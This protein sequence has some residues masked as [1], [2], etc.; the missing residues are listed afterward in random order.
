MHNASQK[1][2]PI[3]M[4]NN[5]NIQVSFHLFSEKLIFSPTT[6]KYSFFSFT[7]SENLVN[8]GKTSEHP[9]P[10][11]RHTGLM[12]LER[13]LAFGHHSQNGSSC[14][15]HPHKSSHMT[16]SSLNILGLRL[17]LRLFDEAYLWL[18]GRQILF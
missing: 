11:A 6:F 2:H 3:C 16:V 17:N 1:M 13:K 10:N 12:A 9:S 8:R 15:N 14:N 4:Y 18:R 7:T 5:L